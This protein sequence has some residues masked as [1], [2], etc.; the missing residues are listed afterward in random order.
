MPLRP[1][2][3]QVRRYL[4]RLVE[5]LTLLALVTLMGW[6]FVRTLKYTLPFVAGAVLALVLWPLVRSLERRGVSRSVAVLAVMVSL[7][8]LAGVLSVVLVIQVAREAAMWSSA[9][10]DYFTLVQDW[11]T[12]KIELGRS[13]YGQLPPT[14]TTQI[15]AAA[16]RAVAAVQAVF[17]GLATN[18]INF[19]T[20]LPESLFIMAIALIAAYF[21][22]VHR[23]QMAQ[24]VLRLLPPGWP[25]KVQVV[26][27]DVMRAFVGSLRVQVILML[28]SAVL[29][30][31]GMWIAGIKY[32]VILGI[33]FG[34]TGLVPVVGSA[35]L[36]VPWMAGAL[37]LGDTML[38]MKVLVIQLAISLIRHLVEPKILA[39]NVGLDT[40]ST[41]FAL[42]VGMKL[43]GVLG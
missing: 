30:V 24:R 39:D 37:L 33:L 9:V 17:S 23:D 35:L 29:G 5:V 13:W 15:E 34:V 22:L 42:Y 27:G 18:V 41:L 28:M 31:L 32:A 38:A 20:S 14:V 10:P 2:N 11:I 16:D 40:L 4:W 8:L 3:P 36:T 43:M 12:Q 19:I 26:A 1:Q 21:M 6:L 25:A 7:L